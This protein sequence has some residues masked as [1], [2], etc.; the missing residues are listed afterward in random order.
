MAEDIRR[1]ENELLGKI[2]KLENRLNSKIELVSSENKNKFEE[3]E[4]K[5]KSTNTKFEHFVEKNEENR[6]KIEKIDNLLKFESKTKDIL[7]TQDI[8]LTSVS[9]D[10]ESMK[11][12]YD[13][14][15]IDNLTVPGFIGDYCKYH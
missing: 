5:I 11:L 2:K 1:L 3:M 10:I 9:K 7:M 8:K 13:K 15:L 6:I 4:N 12:K 14:F